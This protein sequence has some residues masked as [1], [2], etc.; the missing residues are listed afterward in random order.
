MHVTLTTS[1]FDFSSRIHMCPQWSLSFFSGSH[2]RSSPL[3]LVTST[4]PPSYLSSSL[5]LPFTLS[6]LLSLPPLTSSPVFLPSSPLKKNPHLSAFTLLMLS[7]SNLPPLPPSAPPSLHAACSHRW[8]LLWPGYKPAPGGFA[9]GVGSD[10]VHWEQGQADLRHLLRLQRTQCGLPGDPDRPAE[11]GETQTD[12]VKL[13]QL[14][15]FFPHN[16]MR[17]SGIVWLFSNKFLILNRCN[18][19]LLTTSYIITQSITTASWGC[20]WALLLLTVSFLF[21]IL[22]TDAKCILVPDA[23]INA[24]ISGFYTNVWC[25]FRRRLFLPVGKNSHPI[26]AK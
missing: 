14:F 1:Q 24:H 11:E 15:F 23:R 25:C 20:C 17:N 6:Y 8:S 5:L 4:S 21:Q 19:I 7:P 13:I 16:E 9:A 22:N 10:G 26:V 2:L 3:S 18:R 12:S